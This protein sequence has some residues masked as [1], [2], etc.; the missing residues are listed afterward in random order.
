MLVGLFKEEIKKK[1]ELRAPLDTITL[2]LA[3][4]DG[5]L[6]TAKDAAGKEQPVTLNSM[7]TI[8][9]ALEKAAKAADLTIKPNDKLRIIADVA[10]PVVAG[11]ECVVQ[12]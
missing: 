10:L 1:L 7:D 12:V 8:D 5:T 4:E 3:S 2:Q 11:G 6:F 9:K